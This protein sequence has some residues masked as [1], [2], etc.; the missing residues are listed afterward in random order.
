MSEASDRAQICINYTYIL[1][2]VLRVILLTT[3]N[4]EHPFT[5]EKGEK[6]LGILR[7]SR[8]MHYFVLHLAKQNGDV[9]QSSW[10]VERQCG[11]DGRR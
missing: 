4:R 6:S 8:A 3:P 2:E 11:P 7:R 10:P 5:R 9:I 1:L